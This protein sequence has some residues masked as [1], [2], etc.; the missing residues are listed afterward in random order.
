MRALLLLLITNKFSS[1]LHTSCDKSSTFWRADNPDLGGRSLESMLQGQIIFIA[2]KFSIHSVVYRNADAVLKLIKA[3]NTEEREKVKHEVEI[4]RKVTG[5]PRATNLLACFEDETYVGIF[6]LPFKHTFSQLGENIP[7][8]DQLAYIELIYNLAR[9]LD[10]LHAVNIAHRNVTADNFFLKEN[11]T[12]QVLIGNFESAYVLK[13][14]YKASESVVPFQSDAFEFSLMLLSFESSEFR[15]GY[16]DLLK[17]KTSENYREEQFQSAILKLAHQTRET[18]NPRLSNYIFKWLVSSFVTKGSLLPKIVADIEA[19]A[20][21]E[22]AENKSKSFDIP[23]NKQVILKHLETSKNQNAPK[24][25]QVSTKSPRTQ[26][27]ALIGKAKDK[28]RKVLT[29]ENSSEENFKEAS[30]WLYSKFKAFCKLLNTLKKKILY[31]LASIRFGSSKN[32]S[33]VKV[34]ESKPSNIIATKAVNKAENVSSKK[35]P[36]EVTINVLPEKFETSTLSTNNK[37]DKGF[38]EVFSSVPQI[39]FILKGKH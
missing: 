36:V 28:A 32:K 34:E 21:A 5:L 33:K 24:T 6:M 23:I 12:G 10:E 17:A 15:S 19:L 27:E 2:E 13:D 37:P 1:V 16:H 26:I 22:I 3:R 25:N 31:A 8:K 18:V 35:K 38:L 29:S 39:D 20:K 14:A 11:E 9:S 7:K 30:S 4:L